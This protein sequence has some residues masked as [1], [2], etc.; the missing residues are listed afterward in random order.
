MHACVRAGRAAACHCPS[1]SLGR[2]ARAAA[3]G[4]AGRRRSACTAAPSSASP[5]PRWMACC[6]P[7][8][9]SSPAGRTRATAATVT[10]RLRQAGFLLPSPSTAGPQCCWEYA[11]RVLHAV[12]RCPAFLTCMPCTGSLLGERLGCFTLMLVIEDDDGTAV[13]SAQLRIGCTRA[14]PSKLRPG[15][16]GA[17][18]PEAVPAAH[19]AAA[20]AREAVSRLAGINHGMRGER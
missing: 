17:E 10:P 2:A 14:G 16:G 12:P 5:R 13:T 3:A 9:R 19:T 20:H 7:D 6:A 18:E 8:R 11:C 1:C 15:R 4:S